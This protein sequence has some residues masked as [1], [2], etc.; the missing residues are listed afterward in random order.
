MTP[1]EVAALEQMM[2]LALSGAARAHL[3]GAGIMQ[4]PPHGMGRYAD[5]LAPWCVR[6]R[7]AIAAARALL[8]EA[9]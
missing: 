6:N 8:L 7:D 5:C 9:S 2:A 3:D 4:D 1:I